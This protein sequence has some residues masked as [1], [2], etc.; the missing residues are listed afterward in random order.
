MLRHILRASAAGTV[1]ATLTWWWVAGA[2]P[3][4]RPGNQRTNGK[5]S[6]AVIATFPIEQAYL[7][8]QSLT[9]RTY[10][11]NTGSAPARAPSRDS[12]PQYVYLLKS[13]RAET[14]EY[15]LS[16]HMTAVRRSPDRFSPEPPAFE[17]VPAGAKIETQE[18][19]A[20]Y[21]NE[22]FQP[23]KYVLTA[24]LP[25]AGLESPKSIVNILP[26]EVES[27]SSFVS[28]RQLT[29]VVAHR[30]TDG[31]ITILQRESDVLDP[32]EG[33]FH[34]RLVLPKGG[35]VSVATAP[36]VV[37]AGN[38]RWFAYARDGKLN[39]SV[40]FGNRL[41]LTV[42]PVE[43]SGRLLNPGFQVGVGTGLFGV[44]S[45]T[46]RLTTFLA[47]G[48]GLK[49][50]WTA[51]LEGAGGK[52]LWNA[53]PDGSVTI[54]WE[55]AASGRVAR[56]SF[57][58]DGHATG[59]KQL[60]SPGRPLAWGLPEQGPP[61]VWMILS[62]GTSFVVAQLPVAGGRSLSRMP[63]ITAPTGWDFLESAKGRKSVVAISGGRVVASPMENPGFVELS[64]AGA[65]VQAPHIISLT[66]NALWVEWTE[67]GFGIRRARLG[68]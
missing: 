32:R 63:L 13:Q 11:E 58:R 46:G 67:P 66:G 64:P 24:R 45:P 35:P 53:Q 44:I 59:E 14:P 5:M 15:N 52:V 60:I 39:A 25:D 49:P 12:A 43:A 34:S 51:N 41:L 31:Q 3:P 65:V 62:D 56:Q 40:G 47:T 6:D 42:P 7:S 16:S 30:R 55:E 38:G 22:G 19:I 61:T 10:F 17:S 18:D 2:P 37:P 29:S 27:L 68:K 28:E 23:G 4:Q 8:G 20:E 50:H 54:A 57:T 33:V 36:S 9:V 21:W 48:A 26:M 1:L